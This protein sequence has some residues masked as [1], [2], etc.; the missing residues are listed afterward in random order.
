MLAAAAREIFWVLEATQTPCFLRYA[1][2][3]LGEQPL[4]PLLIGYA[5][6]SVLST[7]AVLPEHEENLVVAVPVVGK[8][9]ESSWGSSA[10][11]LDDIA[12]LSR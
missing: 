7:M 3:V 5:W 12:V 2:A 9:R 8:P 10:A 11:A 6:W 4:G 1:E